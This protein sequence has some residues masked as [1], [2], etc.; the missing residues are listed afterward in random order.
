MAKKYKL[1][2]LYPGSHSLGTQFE[3][4]E[5]GSY[6]LKLDYGTSLRYDSNFIEGNSEFFEEVIEVPEYVECVN[7]NIS[8]NSNINLTDFKIGNVYKTIVENSSKSKL[9]LNGETGIREVNNWWSTESINKLYTTFKPSTKEAYDLQ[10]LNKKFVVGKWY[11][12]STSN[13][14]IIK[15]HSI[16]DSYKIYST[17]SHCSSTRTS[18]NGGGTPTYHC[19]VKSINFDTLEELTTEEIQQYLP[20]GHPDKIKEKWIPKAGDWVVL[21]EDYASILKKGQVYKILKPQDGTSRCFVVDHHGLG[22]KS[23]LAPFLSSLRKA[24]PYEIPT[25]DTLIEYSKNNYQDKDPKTL[26]LDDVKEA[27]K[28]Y[29]TEEEI[30]NYLEKKINGSKS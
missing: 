29:D 3:K 25:E 13:L 17:F 26:T 7:L 8:L 22:K 2:K 5:T 14:W 24:L 1:K 11:K 19:N 10:E 23:Y 27:I 15:F 20:E 6:K 4:T 30:V 16:V 12:F 18:Y 21:M 28:L 9:I